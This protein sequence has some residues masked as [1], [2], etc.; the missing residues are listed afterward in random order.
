[1]ACLGKEQLVCVRACVHKQFSEFLDT[2][3]G[4]SSGYWN[5]QQPVTSD[6]SS[7]TVLAQTPPDGGALGT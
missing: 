3:T 7:S 4:R 2:S 6:D 5:F 1:M